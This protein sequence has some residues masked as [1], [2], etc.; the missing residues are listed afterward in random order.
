MAMLVTNPL[1]L[2]AVPLLSNKSRTTKTSSTF[3]TATSLSPASTYCKGLKRSEPG[4]LPSH[5]MAHL[6]RCRAGLVLPA[7]PQSASRFRLH[8]TPSLDF[9]VCTIDSY[10]SHYSRYPLSCGPT[11]DPLVSPNFIDRATSYHTCWI[12]PLDNPTLRYHDQ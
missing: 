1:S 7:A 6:K 3:S 11:F 12:Y 10:T 8:S 2:S 4:P 5:L 9:Y